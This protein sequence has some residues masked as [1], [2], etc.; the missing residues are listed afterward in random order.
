M[1]ILNN[2]LSRVMVIFLILSSQHSIRSA[3]PGRYAGNFQ[4]TK[5]DVT[6][7][8]EDTCFTEFLLNEY[9]AK[10]CA[11][12]WFNDP[13]NNLEAS[14]DQIMQY[15]KN[16]LSPKMQ[17]KVLDTLQ[18]LIAQLPMYTVGGENQLEPTVTYKRDYESFKKA[19]LGSIATSL[20]ERCNCRISLDLSQKN[21]GQLVRDDQKNFIDLIN[22]LHANI[23]HGKHRRALTEL[24]LNFNE[25]DMLPKGIFDQLNSLCKLELNHN[26]LTGLSTDIF[27]G[28]ANIQSLSITDN[29]IT[30]LPAEIFANL[31]NL[32]LLDISNNK[33]TTLPEE[34]FNGTRNLSMLWLN[35]NNIAMLPIKIFANLSDL[36]TIQL[37]DNQL[38]TL[39]VNT[40]SGLTQLRWLC[41]E[42]NPLQPEVMEV[43]REA[44]PA[45]T[46][47]S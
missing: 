41:L 18:V 36:H 27:A 44:L 4:A 46:E 31:T 3:G 11:I 6:V 5:K 32:R 25:L 34:I 45:T 30:A 38:T 24:Y 39:P 20:A 47:I 13:V 15:C 43:I 17:K 37:R 7:Y 9:I 33:L 16:T 40:F 14:T 42:G 21:L 28:V 35:N 29:N 26:N 12:E 10:Q 19:L 1:L 8:L 2:A 23:T 22:A